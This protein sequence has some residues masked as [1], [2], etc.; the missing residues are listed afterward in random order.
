MKNV[1]I[2][3]DF[4]KQIKTDNTLQIEDSY[5]KVHII[6]L[7]LLW[8]VQTRRRTEEAEKG[9]RKLFLHRL[10]SLLLIDKGCKHLRNLQIGVPLYWCI[11]L[12]NLWTR[13]EFHR[14]TINIKEAQVNLSVPGAC[15]VNNYLIVNH[16][17]IPIDLHL[18]CLFGN[19]VNSI[20]E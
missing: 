14:P 20:A 4:R 19:D 6:V 7:P 18:P 5:P 16:N 17:R 1:S 3:M 2:D 9:D 10:A 12:T 15:T 13:T 11:N 8:I